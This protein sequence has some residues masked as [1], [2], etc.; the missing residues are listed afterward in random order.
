MFALG[1]VAV[2]G[3]LV[4]LSVLA[5]DRSGREPDPAPT[6]ASAPSDTYSGV[7]DL[8]RALRRGGIRCDGLNVSSRSAT[9]IVGGQFGFCTIDGGNVNIHV[10]DDPAHVSEHVEN[11]VSVRG[12][13]PNYFTSLVAGSNWVVDTYSLETAEKIQEI[14][15]GQIH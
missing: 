6:R 14:L 15:G 3:L 13:D 9:K 4:S 12:T 2:V 7:R 10:Y 8:A 11:N 1:V 5:R